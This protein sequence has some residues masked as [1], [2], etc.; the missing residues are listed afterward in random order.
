M[1]LF[2]ALLLVILIILAIAVLAIGIGGS[3]IV[4]VFGD[5]IVCIALLVFIFK[6]LFKKKG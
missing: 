1:I 4:L 2:T 5:L 6:H 3:A